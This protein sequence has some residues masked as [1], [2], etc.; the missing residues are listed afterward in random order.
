[1]KRDTQT[2]ALYR[3]I[4][5]GMEHVVA[6]A[7]LLAA[8]AAGHATVRRRARIRGERQFVRDRCALP[9]LWMA[10]IARFQW[11]RPLASIL[12][13]LAAITW[14]VPQALL[15]TPILAVWV[16]LYRRR[17]AAA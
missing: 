3:A 10:A 6:R 13:A 15:L 5:R 11:N 8:A 1:V 7:V 4:D 2:A 9:G 17:D 14:T 12:V 16:W